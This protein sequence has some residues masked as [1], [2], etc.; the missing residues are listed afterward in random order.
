MS[1]TF[2][3]VVRDLLRRHFYAPRDARALARQLAPYER[4]TV[5]VIGDF[6]NIRPPEAR[7]V[8][9][10]SLNAFTWFNLDYERVCRAGVPYMEQRIRSIDVQNLDNIRPYLNSRQLLLIVTIHMGMFPLGFL[11]LISKIESEREVFVF[12]MSEQNAHEVA[13]FAAYERYAIVPRALRPSEGG[14]RKAFMELRRGNIVVM[15]VDLEINV[16]MRTPVSF[17][18]RTVMM[19]AGPATLAALTGATVLPVINF[20]DAFGNPVLRIEPPITAE[21][22]YKG[23]SHSEVV[24]RVTQSIAS[25]VESWIRIDPAQVHAWSSL[26]ETV[27]RPA[28]SPVEAA[29]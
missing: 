1:I 20:Q 19:Q 29:E 24:R 6:L 15:A 2:L 8:Y 23:E 26:A 3:G 22:S 27:I 18:G 14:G 12:K 25:V 16:T 9:L 7:R 17:L 28:N 4:T 13:M 10:R 11:R 5:R 21:P